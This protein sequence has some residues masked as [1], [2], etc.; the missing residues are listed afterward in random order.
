MIATSLRAALLLAGSLLAACAQAADCPSAFPQQLEANGERL[1]LRGSGT[2][3]YLIFDV[4]DAA[5]YTAPEAIDAPMPD[6]RRSAC[7]EICYHREIAREDLAKAADQILARQLDPDRLQHISPHIHRIHDAYR[8]VKRGDRYRMC[9]TPPGN[10]SF[11]FNGKPQLSVD[12]EETGLAYLGIWLG[13][14]ALSPSL[15][16]SLLSMR[17]SAS[18]PPSHKR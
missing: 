9:F 13:E 7:L 15:R 14:R 3:Q 10:M 2:A 4:Y 18:R 16:K 8:D 12:D 1:V 17:V 6:P 5:L 11:A